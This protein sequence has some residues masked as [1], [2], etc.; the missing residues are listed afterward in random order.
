LIFLA[1]GF[2]RGA[3]S[4]HLTIGDSI[5]W[6]RTALRWRNLADRRSVVNTQFG[7]PDELRTTHLLA[8]HARDHA[9]APAIRDCKRRAVGRATIAPS[10]R[11]SPHSVSVGWSTGFPHRGIGR[12]TSCPKCRWL[13]FRLT[14]TPKARAFS[15]FLCRFRPRPYRP[16]LRATPSSA[17]CR[18]KE[19]APRLRRD[20][21]LSALERRQAASEEI[22]VDPIF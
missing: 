11:R 16:L 13:F 10:P 6:R 9:R 17:H 21:R 7:Y 2:L 14:L 20:C 5:A 19:Q 3:R 15:E 4:C 1:C 18:L 8:A 22:V 12:K